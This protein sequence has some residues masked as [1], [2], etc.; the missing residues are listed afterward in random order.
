MAPVRAVVLPVDYP[1]TR[2]HIRGRSIQAQDG[3]HGTLNGVAEFK[4]GNLLKAV[5]NYERARDLAKESR[6]EYPDI[7]YNLACAYS[8]LGDKRAAM[9]RLRVITD[10]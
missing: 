8:R 2:R 9:G 5:D 4:R 10:A 6:Q 7:F 3:R 1:R